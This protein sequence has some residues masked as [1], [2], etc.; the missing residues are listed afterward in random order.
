M[1][2]LNALTDLI[3]LLLLLCVQ[4]NVKRCFVVFRAGLLRRLMLLTNNNDQPISMNVHKGLVHAFPC[5]LVI[6]RNCVIVHACLS[7]ID[8]GT[9]ATA[10]ALTRC[11]IKSRRSPPPPPRRFFLSLKKYCTTFL[12]IYL[13]VQERGT[14]LPGFGPVQSH[15]DK[16]TTSFK[17]SGPCCFFA[18]RENSSLVFSC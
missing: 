15:Y 17:M 18:W 8:L 11:Y 7:A 14:S 9:Q 16:V 12:A 5:L 10:H 1:S 3:T 2:I 6:L 4:Y 13:N